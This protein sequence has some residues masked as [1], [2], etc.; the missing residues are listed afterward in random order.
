MPAASGDD[1]GRTF[2][3]A[4][5]K[6]LFDHDDQPAIALPGAGGFVE[7]VLLA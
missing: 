3:D 7:P 5:G 1:L 4:A 6:N 2:C